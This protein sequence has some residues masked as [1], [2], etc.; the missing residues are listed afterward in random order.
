MTTMRAYT[1]RIEK[2]KVRSVDD[3]PLPEQA[4]GVLVILPAP[5]VAP[6][7]KSL[8]PFEAYL[9]ALRANP[10][11]AN[12]DEVSDE[13]LNRIVHEVRAELHARGD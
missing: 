13:E 11:E 3:T 4:Y 5:P 1:V 8:D 12:I 9:A 10:P 7:D 2:G 6:A